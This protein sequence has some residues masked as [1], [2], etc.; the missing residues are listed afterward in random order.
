[1]NI[2]NYCAFQVR[3]FQ[4]KDLLR[5][6]YAVEDVTK[7]EDRFQQPDD[8]KKK[9]CYYSGKVVNSLDSRVALSICDGVVS[10][11]SFFEMIF[12]V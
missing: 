1:M 8:T 2:M 10:C 6:D 3:M 4:N 11:S 7:D 5:K 12:N 9:G